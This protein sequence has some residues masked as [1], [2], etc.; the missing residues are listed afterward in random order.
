MTSTEEA[1]EPVTIVTGGGSGIGSAVAAH[2]ARHGH[3]VVVA[4][5]D[6]ARAEGVAAGLPGATFAQVDVSDLEACHGVVAEVVA[7]VGP[8]TGLVNCAGIRSH[9]MAIS[10]DMAHWRRTLEVNVL[11]TYAMSAAVAPCMREAGGG[12]IVNIS[13]TRGHW[14]GPGRAAYSVSK[15]GVTML[16]RCLA[17]EWAEYG[18]RVNAVSPG[19]IRTPIN[20]WAFKDPAYEKGVIDRTP[21]GRA[22]TIDE[23]A[24]VV[25][26]LLSPAA[27]YVTGADIVV[28]GGNLA[29]DPGLPVPDPSYARQTR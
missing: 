29:G 3:R 5:L 10:G 19:Y 17:L 28:D 8:P 12:A 9:V 4:D 1:R 11:G 14:P 22:G 6:G 20:E 25:Q 24:E 21:L 13:S 7:R 26:F 2:L 23:V 27:S 15:A 16:T 18:I